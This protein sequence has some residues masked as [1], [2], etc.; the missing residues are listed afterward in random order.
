[1]AIANVFPA[2]LNAR[3]SFSFRSTAL[4]PTKVKRPVISPASAGPSKY[5][6]ANLATANLDLETLSKVRLFIPL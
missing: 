1:M 4:A 6:E 2:N 3:E 5:V